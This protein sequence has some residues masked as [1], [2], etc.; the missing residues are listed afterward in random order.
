MGTVEWRLLMDRELCTATNSSHMD[1]GR[2]LRVDSIIARKGIKFL[3]DTKHKGPT[4]TPV[5]ALA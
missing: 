1:F 2:E 3:N 5:S 4:L